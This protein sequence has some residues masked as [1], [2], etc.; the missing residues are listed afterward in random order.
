MKIISWNCC[1]GLDDT[2]MEMIQKMDADI[3]VIQKCKGNDLDN[4]YLPGNIK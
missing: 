3:Y 2:K 4:F 1:Y